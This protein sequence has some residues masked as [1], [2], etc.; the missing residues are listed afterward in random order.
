MPG[1]QSP[2]STA[3][4]PP[5]QGG[6]M[7]YYASTFAS[8]NSPPASDAGGSSAYG[9]GNTTNYTRQSHAPSTVLSV[10]NA[11]PPVRASPN[12]PQSKAAE[13]GLLSI[14]QEATY[15]ADS[16]V[17]FGP[18]GEPSGSGSGA[19]PADVPPIYTPN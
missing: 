13:A 11:A 15:H 2:P 1:P 12:Q 16:G 5:S 14:P 4:S 18:S 7:S 17:R 19:V 8:T 6:P 3:T 9:G 10:A